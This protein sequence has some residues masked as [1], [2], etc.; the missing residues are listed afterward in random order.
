MPA[1]SLIP[2]PPATAAFVLAAGLGL[3]GVTDAPAAWAQSPLV[4][5]WRWNP[6]E[7]SRAP[8]QPRE[9][10]LV[11]TAGERARVAWT[12]TGV[13]AR[14]QPHVHAFQGTGDGKPAPVDGAPEGTVA[15]FTVTGERMTAAYDNR[16]GSTARTTCAVDPARP[17]LVCEGTDRDAAGVTTRFRDVYDRR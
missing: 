6:T 14:G 15:A 3:L 12:L 13:D 10:V 5:E 2:R 9:V 8:D 7:S 16:D 11:I 4:G 17:R 1:D